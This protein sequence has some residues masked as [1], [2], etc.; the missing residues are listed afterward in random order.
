[1][2]KPAGWDSFTEE[3]KAEHAKQLFRS[4]RGAYIVS[5]ALFYAIKA[6][7]AVKPEHLQEQSNIEDM[8]VLRETLFGLFE[9]MPE[10]LDPSH[11]GTGT[12]SRG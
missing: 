8:E 10:T 9:P 2:A 5:Q 1:M 11:Y 3:Q 7:K 4:F 6:L 12:P